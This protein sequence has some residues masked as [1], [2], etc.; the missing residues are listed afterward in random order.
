MSTRNTT[1][2]SSPCVSII[3][4]VFNQWRYTAACLD[5]LQATPP[6]GEEIEIIVVDNASTDE[7]FT[8]LTRR[9][10]DW[11]A[12]RIERLQ[13]NTGFSPACNR[14]ALLARGDY[15]VFLNNDTEPQPGWLSPLVAEIEKPGVGIAA[16][17]LLYPQS[18]T[19]NHAGY[20]FGS[21]NFYG[22]YH[23]KPADYPGANIPRTYQAVLGACVIIPRA[24]FASLGG[25]SLDGL[26]DIDLCLKA[27]DHGF[28]TRYV[29]SSVVLHHGSV[30]LG[31]SPP[32]SFPVTDHAGFSQRWG[33]HQIEWDDFRWLLEDGEW[34]K[35]NGAA[36]SA[37]AL[38]IAVASMRKLMESRERAV[39]ADPLGEMDLLR[40]SLALWPHNRWAFPRLCVALTESNRRAEAFDLIQRLGEFS[41]AP[42]VLE[43][44]APALKVLLPDEFPHLCPKK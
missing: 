3:I 22:I 32:G 29:P 24:L 14:G 40:E 35:P 5:S 11:G 9:S 2:R 36:D 42:M 44:L 19:I 1:P 27:R 7:T 31:L 8:E 43:D 18:L 39:A 37:S 10:R 38:T 13:T 28:A 25:F 12:L 33:T 4:P 16:P 30:T 26:E 21:G 20:V 23:D 17:K 34:P 15:L 41:F 6:L